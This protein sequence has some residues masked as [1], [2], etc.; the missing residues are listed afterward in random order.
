MSKVV[1]SLETQTAAV[2]DSSRMSIIGYPDWVDIF[3]FVVNFELKISNIPI[4][5]FIEESS[6]LESSYV[7]F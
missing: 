2:L 3:W 6:N 5:V 4:M 1:F 7:I